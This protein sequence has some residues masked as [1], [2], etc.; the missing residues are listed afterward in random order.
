MNILSYNIRGL[1]RGV[2]WSAI[3]RLVSQH[4][5]D[6]LCLQE[7]KKDK[8]DRGVCQ[9]LWGD[10]DL[11]WEIYPAVNSAGGLLC[12]WNDGMFKV[13]RRITGRG[14]ILLEG[15]WIQE[16]QKLFIVNIYAPCEAAAKRELWLSIKQIKQLHTDG[17]WCIVGDFNSIKHP[18]ER[19][20]MSQREGDSNSI[21]EF[22]EWISDLEVEEV[23]SVGRRFTWI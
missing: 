23:P 21:S 11:S 20:T 15:M 3:R 8:I 7:T 16:M 5:V 4:H 6:L 2:K 14:F 18:D 19:L 10:T 12:I 13:E 17:K 22:N 1:G 9:A